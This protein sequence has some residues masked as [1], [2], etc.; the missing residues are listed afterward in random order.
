ML[1]NTVGTPVPSIAT[2]TA[3]PRFVLATSTF[4]ANYVAHGVVRVMVH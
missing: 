3:W 4:K 2:A 1:A